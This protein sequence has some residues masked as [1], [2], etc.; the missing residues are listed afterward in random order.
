MEADVYKQI[1]YVQNEEGHLQ[2]RMEDGDFH[3]K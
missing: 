1:Y 2:L 3:K